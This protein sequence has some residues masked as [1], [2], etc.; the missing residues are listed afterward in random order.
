MPRKKTITR[1]GLRPG[2]HRGGHVSPPVD[3]NSPAARESKRTFESLLESL[4]DV[5]A[6]LA[7]HPSDVPGLNGNVRMALDLARVA[8]TAATLLYKE[9]DPELVKRLDRA[10]TQIQAS[11]LAARRKAA[12][13]SL[14]DLA[15]QREPGITDIRRP[16][17]AANDE[18]GP[19]WTRP[20]KEQ[21]DACLAAANEWRAYFFG[22]RESKPIAETAAFL[23]LFGLGSETPAGIGAFVRRVEVEQEQRQ[24]AARRALKLDE[25]DDK[26]DPDDA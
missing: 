10:I 12:I 26:S 25:S 7:N 14:W 15:R 22:L 17:A 24:L 4:E 18:R 2:D 23:S 16:I 19:R 1:G 6:R 11:P 21:L 5:T 8:A 9:E 13:V 3:L 20:P